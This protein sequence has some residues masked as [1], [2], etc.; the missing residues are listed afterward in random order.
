MTQE[1]HVIFGTGPLGRSVMKELLRRGQAV[2]MVSRTGRMAD[3]PE[4]VEIIAVDARDPRQV[5][6]AA[7]GAAVVYNCLAPAY[8]AVAWETE[9]PKLWGNLMEAAAGGGA[10]LVIGDNLYIYD[11]APGPIREDRPMSAT[12]RKGRARIK[13]V[14]QMLEAHRAGRVRVTFGRGS[15]FFGPYATE[16]SHLGSRVFPALLTGRTVRMIHRL[17]LSHTFTYIEDF[18]R[19][20]VTLGEH[21]LALGQVWHVPNPPTQTPGEVLELAARLA[22]KPL[23]VEVLQPWMLNLV[24]LAVPVVR[25]AAE[26]RYQY[27]K[28]YVVDSSKFERAFGI[29][30]TP[31]EAALAKTLE[32]YRQHRRQG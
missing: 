13:A 10:K 31:M 24:G 11:Q 8:T 30:A 23:K 1:L 27:Q 7:R 18:G 6:T 12:T 3:S 4:E 16:Q 9:L 14:E 29:K 32:F 19:A 5:V 17:D 15:D 25:E 28:P 21:D 22:A 2:R 20:L 26:M